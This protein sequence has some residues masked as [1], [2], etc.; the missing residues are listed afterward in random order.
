MAGSELAIVLE[1]QVLSAP[2]IDSSMADGHVVITGDF[3]QAQATKL[4]QR[5]E[6]P[7]L[8]SPS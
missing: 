1:D 3:D 6:G 2:V 8:P 5:I 4:A 7:S